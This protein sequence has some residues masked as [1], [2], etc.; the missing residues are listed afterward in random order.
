MFDYYLKQRGLHAKYKAPF[1]LDY[2]ENR[3]CDFIID[4]IVE[5]KIV[6]ELKCIQTGFMPENIAQVITY[7]HLTNIR[8]GILINFGLHQAF[9][10]RIIFDAQREDNS[11]NWDMGFFQKLKSKKTVDA[12][13]ASVRNI[14]TAFGPGYHSEVYKRA[15]SIEMNKNQETFEKNVQIDIQVKNI[16]FKPITTDFLLIDRSFLVAI[17]A[18][19][20]KPRIYDVFRMRS[21]LRHLKL[22]HGLIAFWSRT[23]LQLIGIYQS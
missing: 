11:E 19:T 16:S 10:K 15:F 5:D 13:V 18:G 8:L 1:H 4:E 23:N 2:L 20:N 14:D 17:L 6:I 12:I 22:H 9:T 3:I 7:L 21:Y